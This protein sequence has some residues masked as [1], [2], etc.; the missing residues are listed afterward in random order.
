M[1]DDSLRPLLREWQA[2]EPPPGM[3]ARLLAAWRA[4]Y[5]APPRWNF[6]SARVSIPAPLLAVA[7][8]VLLALFLQFRPAPPEPLRGPSVISTQVD[9]DGFHA[10]PDGA[11]RG[12]KLDGV[13]Q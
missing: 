12:V 2:P 7:V 11:A 3:D 5:P 4:A 13:S 8:L 9:A 1:P 6:W 10:L